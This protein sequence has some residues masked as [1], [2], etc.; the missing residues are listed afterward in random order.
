M[1]ACALAVSLYE[2]FEGSRG[3]PGGTDL[4]RFCR[5]PLVRWLNG[6]PGCA[7]VNRWLPGFSCGLCASREV[8]S[9]HPRDQPDPV[10][11][12]ANIGRLIAAQPASFEIDPEP[13]AM[14][15]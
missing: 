9:S 2:R 14:S 5:S 11:A 6:V 15:A 12:S 10:A 1:D 13:S 7:E 4:D 3:V 8:S